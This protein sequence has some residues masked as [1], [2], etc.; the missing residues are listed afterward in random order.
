[1]AAGVAS[2]SSA[3]ARIVGVKVPVHLQTFIIP[4]SL[5]VQCSGDEGMVTDFF[6]IP[7]SRFMLIVLLS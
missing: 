5:Q 6:L 7:K 2:E 1:M 4:S 3:R